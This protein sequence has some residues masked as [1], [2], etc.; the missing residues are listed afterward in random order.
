MSITWIYTDFLF[1]FKTV[2]FVHNHSIL[3]LYLLS[4]TQ[5]VILKIHKMIKFEYLIIIHLLYSTCHTHSHFRVTILILPSPMWLLKVKETVLHFIFSSLT[6]FIVALQ[7]VRAFSY[8]RTFSLPLIL[9]FVSPASNYIL[10][11]CHSSFC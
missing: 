9:L 2:E 7:T 1:E 11:A 4:S 6:I 5:R 8:Y 3:H 10:N